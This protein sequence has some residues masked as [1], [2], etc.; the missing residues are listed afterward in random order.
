MF[1]WKDLKITGTFDCKRGL[2]RV[3]TNVLYILYSCHNKSGVGQS[4]LVFVLQENFVQHRFYYDS[5]V[6]EL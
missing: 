1:A 6:K 3:F 4:S 2:Q 5:Y